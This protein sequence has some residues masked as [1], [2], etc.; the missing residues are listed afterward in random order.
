MLWQCYN[1]IFDEIKKK[2]HK[3]LKQ[4]PEEETNDF[5]EITKRNLKSFYFLKYTNEIQ[6]TLILWYKLQHLILFA[7]TFV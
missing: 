6:D 3:V 5:E 4:N 7:K 2:T 1:C